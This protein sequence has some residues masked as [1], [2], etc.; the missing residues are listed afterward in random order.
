MVML[1]SIFWGTSADEAGWFGL[2]RSGW[3]ADLRLLIAA[4]PDM[5]SIRT[6]AELTIPTHNHNADLM[7][8]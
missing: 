3:H 4:T 2:L 7:S 1:F 8:S 5:A 6:L